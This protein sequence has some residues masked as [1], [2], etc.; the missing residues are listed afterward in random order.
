LINQLITSFRGG[1][2]DSVE[3]ERMRLDEVNTS[4]E[5]ENDSKGV[6]ESER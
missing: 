4:T 2:Y 6:G 1:E 5:V 3:E